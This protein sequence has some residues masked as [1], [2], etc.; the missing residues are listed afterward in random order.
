MKERDSSTAENDQEL[1]NGVIRHDLP[2]RIHRI[3]MVCI[4]TQPAWEPAW[5][6]LFDYSVDTNRQATPD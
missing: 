1:T 2:I 4:M 6:E 5:A 3:I